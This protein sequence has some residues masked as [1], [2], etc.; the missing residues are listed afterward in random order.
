MR[1]FGGAITA[2]HRLDNLWRLR[3]SR[4]RALSVECGQRLNVLHTHTPPPLDP[5][6][7]PSTLP[8]YLHN[9]PTSP[10]SADGA[11]DSAPG[12][13]VVGSTVVVVV[14]VLVF[15]GLVIVVAFTVRRKASSG[16]A[17]EKDIEGSPEYA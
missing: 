8:P 2:G 10:E 11:S 13:G 17:L 3:P 5:S 7:P 1:L 16:A 14:S 9:H 12:I 6:A 4:L 15:I